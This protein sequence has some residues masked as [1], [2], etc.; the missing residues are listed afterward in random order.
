MNWPYAS[1]LRL[2][3]CL[4]LVLGTVHA[5]DSETKIDPT[6]R[7]EKFI[8]GKHRMYGVW[9]E[10]GIWCIRSTSGRRVKIEFIGLVEVDGDKITPDYSALEA[11]GPKKDRDLV[12]MAR[13]RKSMGFRF[14]TIGAV[15]GIDFKVGP[16]AKT[17]TFSLKIADDDD[18]K[19]IYIGAKGVNPTKA[20]F[21]LPA[22][23]I[24]E[25]EKKSP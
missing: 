16:K 9:Y 20:K 3:G 15:D 2:L 13:N 24:S 7:P 6:G 19:F 22:H 8:S 17:V 4:F 18:P 1:S 11:D 23:P 5:E 21:A 25:D 14:I 12:Q 10:D